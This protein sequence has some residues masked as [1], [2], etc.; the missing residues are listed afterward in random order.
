MIWVIEVH[1]KDFE[2]YSKQ[3]KKPME[4]FD[5]RRRGRG[6]PTTFLKDPLRVPSTAQTDGFEDSEGGGHIY[7]F[8]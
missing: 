6:W 1:G 5:Q 8:L 2:F 7:K 3:K 4:D